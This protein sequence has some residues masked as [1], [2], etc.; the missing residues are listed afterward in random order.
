MFDVNI[1]PHWIVSHDA[2]QGFDAHHLLSLLTRVQQFDSIAEAA[3]DM[4]MSYGGA[5]L[6]VKRAESR[7]G[8]KLLLTHRGRGA[9][10]T[11]LAQTLLWADRRLTA[12]LGPTLQSFS[13]ELAAALNALADQGVGHEQ[14]RV[15]LQASHGFAVAALL[16]Q[17]ARDE[18]V[19][20]LVFRN[21]SEAL[22]S[23]GRRDCDFAGF[24]VPV[25]EFEAKVVSHYS[26][27]L[28]PRR[29]VL[30][31]LAARTQGLI[32]AAGNPK[33]LKA[34]QDLARSGVRFVNRQAGSGTRLLVDLMLQ[35]A[36]VFPE[37]VRGYQ[38]HEFTHAAVAAFVASGMADAGVGVETAARK[39]GMDF[40][41][42]ARER[43]F[44]A[45]EKESLSTKPVR[46]VIE[47]V[48]RPSFM[49]RLQALVGYDATLT[50][51]VQTTDEAFAAS[52][53]N[54]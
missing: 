2:V 33:R 53:I 41:P 8:A 5:L 26:R 40:V 23:L 42:L 4:G 39:F 38:V 30:L 43:Y 18:R 50:G 51:T 48:Q 12:R 3:R 46:D 1:E 35:G 21:S 17:L 49:R 25:G 19:V 29:H 11:R 9:S 54:P 45:L 16:D 31:H 27:W 36:K 22:A 24:H 20:D 13:L 52:S 47:T 14:S 6:L 10:L 34:I 7:L 44:L 28:D 15:R 37:D 32:V